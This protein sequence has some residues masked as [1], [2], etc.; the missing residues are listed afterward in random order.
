M[1]FPEFTLVIRAF[2]GFCGFLSV[3]MEA[4]GEIT[5]H[6]LDFSCLHICV[7]DFGQCLRVKSAAEWALEVAEF[8]NCDFCVFIPL[9]G[10]IVCAGLNNR[11]SRWRT[12]RGRSR[13]CRGSS[14][15]S[16]KPARK[17]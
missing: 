3:L 13:W 9:N 7:F 6:K 5:I 11:G 2:R 8:D 12:G 1:V 10:V 17:I 14:G 16:F 4:Q 15:A